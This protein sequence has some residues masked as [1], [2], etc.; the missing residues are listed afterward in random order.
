MW[1]VPTLE[2]II[3]LYIIW[4]PYYYP[5]HIVTWGTILEGKLAKRTPP[6]PKY[7]VKL[8]PNTPLFRYMAQHRH[9]T[10]RRYLTQRGRLHRANPQP[11][12]KPA[13]TKPTTKKTQT[14]YT[15]GGLQRTKPSCSLT[16]TPSPYAPSSASTPW[17]KRP[18]STSLCAKRRPTHRSRPRLPFF[19]PAEH[20]QRQP[21]QPHCRSF[22]PARRAP[23]APPNTV[24]T[25]A[26]NAIPES[27]QRPD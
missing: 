27:L 3:R 18:G 20:H 21:A 12:P 15:R 17:P 26:A 19:H 5:P 13:A 2:A 4:K 1:G 6:A 7:E 16:D 25:R 10:R 24:N 9:P 23:S 14:R 22:R 11:P 8:F